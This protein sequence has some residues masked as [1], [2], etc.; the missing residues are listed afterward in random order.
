MGMA[1]TPERLGAILKQG[2]EGI[3]HSDLL[4]QGL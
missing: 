4:I 1:G 3:K 2:S